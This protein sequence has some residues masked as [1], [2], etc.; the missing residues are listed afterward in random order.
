MCT[1]PC[2]LTDHPHARVGCYGH[3]SYG[4]LHATHMF[5]RRS[6]DITS[7][8]AMLGGVTFESPHAFHD[9]DVEGAAP[10]S[11]QTLACKQSALPLHRAG[12]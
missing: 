5:V 7:R 11:A 9:N 12:R 6:S 2:I 8:Q 1:F 10:S 4:L 3:G